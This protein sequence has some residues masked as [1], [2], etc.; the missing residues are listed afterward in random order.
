MLGSPHA[1]TV[2]GPIALRGST[3]ELL[4]LAASERIKAPIGLLSEGRQ[5][6]P[7]PALIIEGWAAEGV[8]LDDGRQQIVRILLRG[9]ICGLGPLADQLQ[10]FA[11]T[12]LTLAKAPGDGVA[13]AALGREREAQAK[14]DLH[15]LIRL[16]RLPALE[17]TASFFAETYERAS[18]AGLLLG[19]FM[20]LPFT[21]TQLSDH[22][23][24]SSVHMN[25]VLQQLRRMGLIE[26]RYRTWRVRDLPALASLGHFPLEA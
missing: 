15:H 3:L 21:Q 7:M 4:R 24:I 17:R 10:T 9:D 19:G 26:P 18:Q 14:R 5:A 16:G 22:L 8:L 1:T 6:V 25:R 12:S 13:A 2:R 20:P 11:I 23:G